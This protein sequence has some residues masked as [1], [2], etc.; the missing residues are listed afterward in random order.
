MTKLLLALAVV[1]LWTAGITNANSLPTIVEGCN[2]Q[3]IWYWKAGSCYLLD[4]S[5]YYTFE[6]RVESYKIDKKT[7]ETKQVC[8]SDD[9]RLQAL[10]MKLESLKNS[11]G[12]QCI[13]VLKIESELKKEIENLFYASNIVVDKLSS[14][15]ATREVEYPVFHQIETKIVNKWKTKT[16]VK[17]VLPRV[18]AY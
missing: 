16:I 17:E 4:W 12:L 13:D 3:T 18:W 5:G 2:N 10:I 15:V 11:N 8:N 1:A 9:N 7:S 14:D 6:K